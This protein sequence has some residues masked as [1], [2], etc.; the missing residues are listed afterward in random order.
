MHIFCLFNWPILRKHMYNVFRVHGKLREN[1][2]IGQVV[3]KIKGARVQG[4][5]FLSNDT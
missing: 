5:D 1:A 3:A 2:L 4:I